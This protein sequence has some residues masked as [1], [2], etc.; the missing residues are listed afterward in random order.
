MVDN[1]IRTFDVTDQR[2]LAAFEAIPRELFLAEALADLAYSDANLSCACDGGPRRA[3]L[4]PMILARMIQGLDL[5]PADRALVVG[6]GTGYAAALV[7]ELC[8]SVT[9]LE[10]QAGFVEALRANAAALSPAGCEAALGPLDRGHLAGGPYTA[11]LVCGAVE[12][13]LEKLL[14]QLG[15]GG[16]LVTIETA[17]H[18]ATR[19]S[20]K[21]VRFDRIGNDF[22]S[23]VLFD[24][25]APV[26]VEVRLEP[27]FSF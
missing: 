21:V 18:E 8:P 17:S 24:A 11:I 4:T 2:V 19:R 12:R 6:C 3:L 26:L 10:N 5:G 1:Q 13:G 22:S 14:D 23:R 16:R 25:T 9:A 7:R 15:S 20:G 27:A